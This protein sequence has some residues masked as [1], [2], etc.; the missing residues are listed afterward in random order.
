MSKKTWNVEIVHTRVESF[1]LEVNAETEDEARDIAEK[2]KDDLDGAAPWHADTDFN[3]LGC[4]WLE[5]P[6]PTATFPQPE[7]LTKLLD[8]GTPI[9]LDEVK[10]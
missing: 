4:V 7:W 2:Q 6:Q 8:E 1:V 5:D 10:S 9:F 3:E